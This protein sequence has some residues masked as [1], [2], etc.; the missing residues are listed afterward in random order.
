MRLEMGGPSGRMEM[1]QT[2]TP[3]IAGTLEEAVEHGKKMSK[4]RKEV[5]DEA[6]I[7]RITEYLNAGNPDSNKKIRTHM[8]ETYNAL[9]SAYEISAA[10]ILAQ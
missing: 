2:I 10:R 8:Q 5:I 4:G 6:N 7:V 1:Q 9:V 3:P